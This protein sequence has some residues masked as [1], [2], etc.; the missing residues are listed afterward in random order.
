MD[1]KHSVIAVIVIDSGHSEISS[2]L[3][4]LPSRC[5]GGET[6]RSDATLILVPPASE[7]ESRLTVGDG[8]MYRI[9]SCTGV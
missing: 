3:T 7:T 1:S 8:I 4:S 5:L 2:S 9:L 6:A